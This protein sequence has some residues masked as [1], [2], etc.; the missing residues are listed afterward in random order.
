MTILGT[1]DVGHSLSLY[2]TSVLAGNEVPAP[3]VVA[4]EASRL[5]TH[6]GSDLPRLLPRPLEESGKASSQSGVR[7][8]VCEVPQAMAS[9]KMPLTG[10]V[11][12]RKAVRDGIILCMR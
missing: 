4:D 11:V 6:I 5:L 1:I 9:S 12:L 10:L 8:K 3:V 7:S 2:R